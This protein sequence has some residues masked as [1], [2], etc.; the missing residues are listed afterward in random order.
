[1]VVVTRCKESESATRLVYD[2]HGKLV[3]KAHCSRP[4]GTTVTISNLF[5]TLP[6]R[7]KE[8]V[9][10]IKKEL[11]KML[12][13]LTGYAVAV[14]NARITCIGV[15]DQGKKNIMLKN[16]GG[17][18]RENLTAIFGAKQVTTLLEIPDSSPTE[19]AL[20]E[21]NAK[22]RS[23]SAKITM[24]GFVSTCSHGLGRSSTD[25]QFVFVNKRPCDFK[26]VTRLVNEIYHQ[27]NRHQYPFLFLDV[28]TERKSV[29]VNV[30]PDKR[31]L[32]LEN[33]NVL[34]AKVKTSLL[35]LYERIPSSFVSN[36][37][38]T[39]REIREN[40][41]ESK[42]PCL[43]KSVFTKLSSFKRKHDG[44]TEEPP[45]PNRTVSFTHGDLFQKYKQP[46][47]NSSFEAQENSQISKHGENVKT[48]AAKILTHATNKEDTVIQ[49]N[50]DVFK[51]E[52]P[53]QLKVPGNKE[54]TIENG[55]IR[56]VFT[57]EKKIDDVANFGGV[58]EP[59]ELEVEF[60][61][62]QERKI[63]AQADVEHSLKDNDRTDRA[64]KSFVNE[65]VL[66]VS[67][68]SLL[69]PK[70]VGH[71]NIAVT[72][73][74]IDDQAR[75]EVFEKRLDISL[76]SIKKKC[77]EKDLERQ[78]KKVERYCRNFRAKISTSDNSL[79]EEELSKQIEKEDFFKMEIIGQFNLGFIIVKFKNDLFI[80]DQHATDEIYNFEDLKANTVLQSQRLV[81]PKS[82]ELTCS[83][84]S[85]L[86]ENLQIFNKNGFEFNIDESGPSSKRI[87]LISL[88]YSRG[89]TFGV[90][91]IEEL[92]FLLQ[93]CPTP[94]FLRPSKVRTMLASRACRKSVMIGQYLS[95]ADMRRLIDHMGMMQLPWNCP[96]GRPT[97]RHLV[98]VGM[99]EL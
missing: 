83:D 18:L 45:G 26:P 9:K 11:Q 32:M 6:V 91:D 42:P 81:V 98:D 22:K 97:M 43:I 39:S 23:T 99:L 65:V 2:R 5:S 51:L 54:T 70:E 60:H 74:E 87:K 89:I 31:Q 36:I 14:E 8:F 12:N 50:R 44:L 82:L 67:V 24:S 88:P 27:Y 53:G 90:S 69:P 48:G 78:R 41:S 33:E 73:I 55:K 59:E 86:M 71:S 92:L 4:V 29:D 10:N 30:T 34:L 85:L 47:L 1:M 68:S 40:G 95:P 7:H 57:V 13:I 93:D 37:V 56:S 15:S 52:E 20:E 58:G 64:G 75:T 96:H 3:S 77:Q 49:D 79:A 17:S 76:E 72:H 66:P 19:E 21:F 63:N 61:V 62:I 46:K 16:S 38:E 25:R 94:Q 80:V 84:E 35:K 28:K